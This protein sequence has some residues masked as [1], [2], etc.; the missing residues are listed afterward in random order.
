[1]NADKIL[2]IVSLLVAILAVF[3]ALDYWALILVLLG[4]L[5]GFMNSESDPVQRMV[6]LVAA[7]GLPVVANYLDAIPLVGGYVN[8]IIDNIAIAISGMV[9]ANFIMAMVDRVKP[10]SGD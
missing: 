8:S 5:S 10:A 3:V 1:M 9:I 6:L 4:L 2:T 7:I